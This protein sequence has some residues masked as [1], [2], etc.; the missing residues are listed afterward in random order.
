MAIVVHCN[1][2]GSRFKAPDNAAGRDAKC[3]KCKATIMIPGDNED[4]EATHAPSPRPERSV[5]EDLVEE[6]DEFAFS[7]SKMKKQFGSSGLMDFLS[8]RTMLLPLI[9]QIIFWLGLLAAVVYGIYLMTSGAVVGGLL[10]ILVGTLGWR[11]YCEL[12]IVFFRIND[13]LTEIKN[14]LQQKQP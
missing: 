9:I 11:I 4:M 6:S 5:K 8:F 2:C 13:T 10:Y 7:R 14:T 1:K 12:M 3:P